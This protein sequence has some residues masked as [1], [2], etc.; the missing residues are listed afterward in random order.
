MNGINAK[1]AVEIIT[2]TVRED[3]AKTLDLLFGLK[4]LREIAHELG[5]HSANLIWEK[6]DLIRLILLSLGF[7]VPPVLRGI[8]VY[9]N[10]LDESI[11]RLERGERTTGVL[12]DVFKETERIL[13]DIAYFYI[14]ALFDI[15]GSPD[16]VER[17]IREVLLKLEVK[18]PSKS[19]GELTL[20]Q[21]IQLLRT[22]NARVR[23]S[24]DLKEK[25]RKLFE[26]SLIHI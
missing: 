7:K 5:L 20:G 1:E 21:Y 22:L 26:L 3:P 2:E 10:S 6:K 23:K 19:L 18:L 16:A 13:R 24:R 4:E 11:K 12:V 25:A 8:V 9:Q 14:C 17:Q 15:Q